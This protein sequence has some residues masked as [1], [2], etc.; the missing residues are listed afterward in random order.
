MWE[1]KCKNDEGRTNI[2]QAPYRASTHPQQQL[3]HGF[4]PKCNESKKYCGIVHRHVV[5]SW[6]YPSFHI[7]V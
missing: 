5:N 2:H 6:R 1:F 7:E 4:L 3:R